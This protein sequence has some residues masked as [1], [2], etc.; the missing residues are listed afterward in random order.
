MRQKSA[1]SELVSV[2]I[3]SYR[4][5]EGIYDTLASVFQQTYSPIEVIVADDGTPNFEQEEPRLRK[6]VDEH[7]PDS[8]QRV[9]LLASK[10][11]QGTV[12]NI[13]RAIESTRGGFIKVLAAEDRLARDDAITVYVDFLSH[14]DFEICFAKMRG[15]TKEG[16]F[17]DNLSSCENN[18]EL[19]SN[20]TP[21][22][23]EN[24][25][26]A[27][28]CLPAPAWCAKRRLFEENGLF[29]E[30]GRLIEDYPY[31]L[32]L[33]RRN[34]RFGF[35]DE[36]LVLYRLSGV[37]SAGHYSE[38]FMNDMFAIY[39]KFVFPHDK[40]YGFAQPFYNALKRAGLNY[41]M[42]L[43]RRKNMTPA[44]KA[45]A[46]LKYAPFSLYTYIQNRSSG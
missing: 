36:P 24:R 34:V 18:Y 2:V 17:K 25:L 8:I 40:R 44:Q 4:N 37:S 38:A 12:K 16:E 29:P 15:V 23:M 39:D 1:S 32:H 5:L 22:Q 30:C 19:L 41:Y 31:W 3:L 14:S 13:N 11:N 10:Q 27:R 20:M 26:F 45:W 43:A 35:I 9:A 28:N 21:T 33:S 42:S 6:Y 46:S 7:K